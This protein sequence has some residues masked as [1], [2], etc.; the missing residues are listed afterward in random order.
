VTALAIVSLAVAYGEAFIYNNLL[1]ASG[2]YALG[3]ADGGSEDDLGLAYDMALRERVLDPIGMTRSTFD[4]ESVQADGDY[5][6]PHAV[7]LSISPAS[8][9]RCP[10]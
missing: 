1:I 4:P 7:D 5:A 2:G 3:V 9:R 6:L 8:C 10:L